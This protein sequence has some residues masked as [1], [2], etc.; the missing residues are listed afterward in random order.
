MDTPDK[1]FPDS[2]FEPR[3]SQKPIVIGE[4]LYGVSVAELAERIAILREEIVRCENELG[5]KQGE[6]DAAHGIFKTS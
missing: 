1:S 3:A 2:V 5:K 4:D 6:M